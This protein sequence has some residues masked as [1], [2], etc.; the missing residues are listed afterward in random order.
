M[1]EAAS[2]GKIVV[3]RQVGRLDRSFAAQA[4]AASIR[5]RGRSDTEAIPA[6][7]VADRGETHLRVFLAD[8]FPP[9][10]HPAEM[11]IG[12][13]TYELDIEVEPNS[14]VWI[15]PAGLA[16]SGPPGGNVSTTFSIENRGNVPIDLP[17]TAVM[18]A[19][20]NDGL[21]TALASTFEMDDADPQHLLG[22]FVLRL[23]DGYA[24]LVRMRFGNAETPLHPGDRRTIKVNATLPAK[25]KN[26]RNYFYV[27]EY[28]GLNIAVQIQST[29]PKDEK[30]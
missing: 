11:Q 29:R 25:M 20:A 28:A 26:G 9:G 12:Q 17:D 10:T 7:I 19:F 23:R 5:I 13:Q 3:R 1:A 27:L 16:L 15:D 21:A 24:G 30:S 4:G 22:H 14:L 8:G 18:G 2:V 6:V